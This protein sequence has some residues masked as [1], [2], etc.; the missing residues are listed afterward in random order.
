MKFFAFIGLLVL[1]ISCKDRSVDSQYTIEEGQSA[2]ISSDGNATLI[3]HDITSSLCGPN[4]NC[5][6]AGEIKVKI[7]A[8]QNS[9]TATATLC[10]GPDCQSQKGQVS[11]LM[12]PVGNR[13]WTIEFVEMVGVAPDKAV[14]T[15]QIQ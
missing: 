15:V 2:Q 8:I 9:K 1:T 14:F 7:E 3:V 4:V 12:L 11:K 10:K 6:R 13:M 5:I